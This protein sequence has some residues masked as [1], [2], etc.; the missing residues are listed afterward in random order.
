VA[1]YPL[2]YP[3]GR[4]FEVPR[5]DDIVAVKNVTGFVAGNRHSYSLRDARPY[6]VSDR[7]TAEVV[8]EFLSGNPCLFASPLPRLVECEDP[9]PS[10]ME[11]E[12]AVRIS[13]T[14]LL[15]LLVKECL[16]DEGEGNHPPVFVL[17]RA[18]VEPNRARLKVY[19]VPCEGGISL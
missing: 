15:P 1:R 13:R 5:R 17:G 4:F 12:G 11:D 8:N 9:F 7:G 6:Q 18:F 10:F 3:S 2:I 14:M 19:A 16:E